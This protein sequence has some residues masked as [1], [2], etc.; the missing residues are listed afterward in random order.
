MGI[1]KFLASAVMASLT[2]GTGIAYSQG[3]VVGQIQAETSVVLNPGSAQQRIGNQEFPYLQGDVVSTNGG[4]SAS[5]MLSSA[6]SALTL[7]PN[8]VASVDAIDPLTI[9]LRQ[10][11]VSFEAV[12]GLPVTLVSPQGTFTVTSASGASAIAVVEDGNFAVVS[13]QGDMLI[14]SDNSNAV[15]TVDN[16]KVFLVNEENDATIVDVAVGASSSTGF[17]GSYTW[18]KALAL[19]G[20]VGAVR[21]ATKSDRIVIIDSPVN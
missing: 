10:G 12:A 6:Q 7:A 1:R 16:G 11:G 9:T 3:I 18:A 20:G 17:L 21:E 2:L 15:V 8:S 19:L 4:K 13:K 5:I 14:Q